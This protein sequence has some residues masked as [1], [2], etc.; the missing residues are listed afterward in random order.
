MGINIKVQVL[1]KYD[2]K[3]I[4]EKKLVV[5]KWPPNVMPKADSTLMTEQGK[6]FKLFSVAF[7]AHSDREKN[8]WPCLIEDDNNEVQIGMNLIVS[9]YDTYH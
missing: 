1:E 4:A 3:A 9:D 2:F 5:L 8:W 7:D 6:K